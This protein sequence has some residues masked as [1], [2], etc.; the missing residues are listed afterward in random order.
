MH[1]GILRAIHGALVILK[2]KERKL[3]FPE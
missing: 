3:I 1:G 2:G